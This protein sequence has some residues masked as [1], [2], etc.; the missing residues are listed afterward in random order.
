MEL[1]KRKKAQ[2]ERQF[3][4]NYTKHSAICNWIKSGSTVYQTLVKGVPGINVGTGHGLFSQ[5]PWRSGVNK[6]SF[7][8]RFLSLDYLIQHTYYATT[9]YIL[10]IVLRCFWENLCISYKPTYPF[11]LSSNFLKSFCICAI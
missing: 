3:L 11:L 5:R 2:K 8:A 6:E 10:Y 9:V 7:D 1:K 4:S